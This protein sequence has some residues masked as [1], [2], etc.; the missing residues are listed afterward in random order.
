MSGIA[1]RVEGVGVGEATVAAVLAFTLGDGEGEALAL[2]LAD[3]EA[4]TFTLGDGE[5]ETLAAGDGEVV[6]VVG[7]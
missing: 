6:L 3:G 7:A 4:L 5:G 1:A 2:T